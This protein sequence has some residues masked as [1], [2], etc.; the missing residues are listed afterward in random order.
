MTTGASPIAALAHKVVPLYSDL[1]LHDMGSLGDGIEQG[2]AGARE[3]KTA[4]LWGLRAR[5]RLLHDGRATTIADA[6]LAHA[7]E[8]TPV[9]RARRRITATVDRFS[10]HP[11]SAVVAD[12]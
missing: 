8:A 6:I 2:A 3:I 4:P 5:S 10:E 7:G 1:L 12:P 11:L 9:R